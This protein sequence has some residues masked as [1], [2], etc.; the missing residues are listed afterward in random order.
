[1]M[2]QQAHEMSTTWGTDEKISIE[3]LTI[4]DV[5]RAWD[6]ATQA[7]DQYEIACMRQLDADTIQQ[8]REEMLSAAAHA[9]NVQELYS[10]QYEARE[11]ELAV[12]S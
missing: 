2:T 9:E 8:R 5:E 1:M 11:A 4:H 12:Q 6:E 10:Q 3:Q 7:A